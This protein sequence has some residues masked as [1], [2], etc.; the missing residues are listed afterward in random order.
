MTRTILRCGGAMMMAAVALAGCQKNRNQAAAG[1]DTTARAGEVS[2]S[3][4]L[5]RADTTKAAKSG[6]SDASI[7]GYAWAANNG[8]IKEAELAEK[9]ATNPAVKAFARQMI[10]D[11]RAMLDEGKAMASKL[12]VKADTANG[13]AH[14]L[15]NSTNDEI[16]DLTNKKMGKDWDDDYIG[17]QVDDHKNVLDKLQDASKNTNNAEL[18]SMLE[19]AVG[20]VQEHLTKAQDIKANKLHA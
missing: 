4:T 5:H 20:K 17:K 12:G 19:K 14:D 10:T 2:A 15:I 8:E 7:L 13:D 1:T 18:R 6:W 16:K 3:D 9:R 11:H